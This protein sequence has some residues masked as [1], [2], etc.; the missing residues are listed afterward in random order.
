MV[1]Y[2]I[3]LL[4]EKNYNKNIKNIGQR[5]YVTQ[6]AKILLLVLY[7]KNLPVLALHII[8]NQKNSNYF[9][10]GF[11]VGNLSHVQ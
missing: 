8:G 6:K 7:I 2:L 9:I 3:G 5:S 11:Y 1:L 4:K 10:E